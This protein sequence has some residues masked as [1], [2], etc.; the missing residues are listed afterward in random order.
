VNPARATYTI[1]RGGRLLDATKRSAEPADILVAQ[2]RIAEIGAPGLPAPAEAIPIDAADKLLLPGLVNAH[3]HGHGHI[4]KGMGDAW[5]LELLLNAGPYLNGGR[6]LEDKQLVCLLGGLDMI[7]HGTTACYDLFLE[8]PLPTLEGLTAAARGYA[9]AGVRVVMAPMFADRSLYE[10]VPGLLDALPPA[11]A[12]LAERY[13][14]A[15]TET[16]LAALQAI[17]KGWS[18]PREQ[19]RLALAPTIPQHCGDPLIVQSIGLARDHGLRLHMHLAESRVQA[20]TGAR[21]YGRTLTRHLASLGALGPDFTA[22][23]AIWLDADD[24]ACL[25]DAG[26]NVAH[27][28]GSNLRLGSGIAP[29]RE[30]LRRSLTLGIGTDGAQCS[31]HQNMFEA[32]RLATLVSRTASPDPADWLRAD[33]ALTAATA[34]SAGVLGF[35]DLI[36]RLVPGFKADIVFLDLRNLNYVPLND[37]LNQVVYVENGA[38][39]ESVMIDGRFVYRDRCFPLVDVDVLR[40]KVAERAAELRTQN[41]AAEALAQKLEKAVGSFCIGLS[42]EPY[43]VHRLLA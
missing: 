7:R 22:A 31:D 2:D 15:P 36:G 42:R 10:A 37:A 14:A 16:M 11:L 19:A 21:R 20:V 12:S 34:G 8:L 17:A 43:H 35:D 40:R 25:A 26:A 24:I 33:E 38:A 9:Q 4:G 30:M 29:V 1:I 23:H 27:N 41:A 3:T 13:R 28:P 32:M 6:T 18:L 5:S 39:V